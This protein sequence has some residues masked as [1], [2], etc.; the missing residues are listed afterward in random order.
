MMF[1]LADKTEALSPGHSISDYPEGFLWRDKRGARGYRIFGSKNQVVRASRDY[2][3]L[4]NTR[5]LKLSDFPCVGRSKSLGSRNPPLCCAPPLRGAGIL[6]LLIL[7][8]P[9]GPW[10]VML[11][12]C[13]HLRSTDMT[14]ASFQWHASKYVTQNS[15]GIFPES[16]QGGGAGSCMIPSPVAVPSYSENGSEE[17]TSISEQCSA[18]APS[19][20]ILRSPLRSIFMTLVQGQGAKLPHL[21]DLQTWRH[22]GGWQTEPTSHSGNLCL[23]S[24]GA[25][26]WPQG[27]YGAQSHPAVLVMQNAYNLGEKRI[28]ITQGPCCTTWLISQNY[29]FN[30]HFLY[31]CRSF[32]FVLS[33]FPNPYGICVSMEGL[34][35]CCYYLQIVLKCI[36]ASLFFKPWCE[37]VIETKVPGPPRSNWLHVFLSFR[38]IWMDTE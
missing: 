33:Q 6:C 20:V 35:L 11:D 25:E 32:P 15:Q 12:G 19:W 26:R 34:K 37:L 17:G 27:H 10:N 23:S 28:I 36:Q 1:Y 13:S 22:H 4:E 24:Q 18:P 5:Q 30:L 3:Q 7:S 31:F 16:H 14:A 8:L 21:P 2:C 9:R 29:I 38:V